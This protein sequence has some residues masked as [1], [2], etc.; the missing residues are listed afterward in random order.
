M[1]GAKGRLLSKSASFYFLF[2][3]LRVFGVL[4]SGATM[5]ELAAPTPSLSYPACVQL[6][7]WNLSGPTVCA[8]MLLKEKDGTKSEEV[9]A[10]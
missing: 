3:T 10:L 5:E 1:R 8:R 6:L 4:G 2:A 9:A 7:P